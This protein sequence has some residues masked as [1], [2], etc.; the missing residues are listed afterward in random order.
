LL[1]V[2]I[3]ELE[4]RELLERLGEEYAHYRQRVPRFIPR[5]PGKA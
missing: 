3:S 1:A 2:A 5:W 4:E